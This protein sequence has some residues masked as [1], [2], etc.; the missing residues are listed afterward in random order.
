MSSP[1]PLTEV[2]LPGRNRTV[3]GACGLLSKTML[4]SGAR[5]T[6]PC[7]ISGAMSVSPPNAAY[8]TAGRSPEARRIVR[9]ALGL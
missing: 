2:R 3:P 9:T 4:P 6:P 8:G 7:S 1:A 5:S